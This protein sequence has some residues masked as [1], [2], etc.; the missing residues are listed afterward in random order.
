MPPTWATATS[1]S[2]SV[3]HDQATSWMKGSTSISGSTSQRAK[4][5]TRKVPAHSSTPSGSC[6]R[7]KRPVADSLRLES[8]DCVTVG[9]VSAT[10]V[11]ACG[12][13]RWGAGAGSMW[14]SGRTLVAASRSEAAMKSA[15][16]AGTLCTYEGYGDCRR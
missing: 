15:S 3:T 5:T 9:D 2:A 12:A 8:A 4:T 14:N 6:R 13:S 11:R 10:K 7:T 1:V 16:D